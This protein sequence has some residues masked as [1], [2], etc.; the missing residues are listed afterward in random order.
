[1]KEKE[2]ISIIKSTLNSQYIGDDCAYLK[3]LGI[4]IT[5]DN[6][7]EDIHFT[8]KT[9][10]PF[11][12]GY[13]SIMVNLSDVASSGAEPAYLTVS[14][15]LPQDIDKNFIKEF[16][17]G[18]KNAC[19]KDVEIVGGDITGADK[20]FISVCAIGKSLN[21][22]IS[23]RK[24]AKVGQKII[25]SG[26]HGSSAAGLAILNNQIECF[27]KE[28][29][30]K[31]HLMPK[32]QIEFGQK[33]SI[34]VQTPYAMM[35]TS[36]GLMDALLTIA[37]ESGVCMEVDFGKI[38]H[39]KGLE[40]FENWQDMILFGGEDYQLLACVPKDFEY[41]LTVGKVKNGFGVDLI[42]NSKTVNYTEKNI[43]NKLFNHF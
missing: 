15:S 39:E 29:F 5:Q 36:D 4:V 17:D 26:N 14:L 43:E 24:N 3:D 13:K 19:G 37:K 32:A 28:R 30:I 42:L 10:T 16:Y 2:F 23:S 6:L 22:N 11:Q 1:M 21:R 25:V 7:V 9:I 12:L 41:G 38:P 33:V 35:D 40:Q 31:A 8:R 34:M 20:I 18:C 27:D